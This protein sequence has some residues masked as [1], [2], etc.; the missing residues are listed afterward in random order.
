[1]DG[2]TV[3]AET[4]EYMLS[5]VCELIEAGATIVDGCCGTTPPHIA[6]IAAAARRH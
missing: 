2:E 4:P 6:A 1:V 3:C 5:R